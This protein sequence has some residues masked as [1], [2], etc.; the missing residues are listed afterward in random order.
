MHRLLILPPISEI[1]GFRPQC[2]AIVNVCEELGLARV[3]VERSVNPTLH[4][5]LNS[6]AKKRNRWLHVISEP[7]SRNKTE[8]IASA[9]EPLIKSRRFYV[10]N[11]VPA[12]FYSELSA[13]PNGKNDDTIDASAGAINS[14]RGDV[15]MMG[16][17]SVIQT[18]LNVVKEASFNTSTNLS[19]F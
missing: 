8:F 3:T 7:R 14:L 2:D 16:R 17:S 6:A 1:D 15:L 4:T 9:L 12:K 5:E 13:F 18:R 11:S 10:H 19:R